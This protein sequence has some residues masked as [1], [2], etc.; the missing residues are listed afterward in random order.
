[1]IYLH[2]Q[3]NL[4]TNY[5]SF[6]QYNGLT[7]AGPRCSAIPYILGGLFHGR[8]AFGMNRQKD[9]KNRSEV[10][11]LIVHLIKWVIVRLSGR[12]YKLLCVAVAKE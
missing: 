11:V 4:F 10:R 3:R 9:S 8:V 12:V 7:L 6:E 1:M 2:T 5:L